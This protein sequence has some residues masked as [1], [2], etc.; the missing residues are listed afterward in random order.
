MCTAYGIGLATAMVVAT[1][2]ES[3]QPALFY[4]TPCTVGM[5]IALSKYNGE[6]QQIWTENGERSHEYVQQVSPGVET[7]VFSEGCD[8]EE[9][10]GCDTTA[11]L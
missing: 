7:T 3:G 11:L 9:D 10:G 2:F 1:V 8:M 4:L 5:F 6:F